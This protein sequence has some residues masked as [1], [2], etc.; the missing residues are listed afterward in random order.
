[1]GLA[2]QVRCQGIGKGGS[3][4]ADPPWVV[5]LG[6]SVDQR[7]DGMPS[8]VARTTACVRLWLGAWDE[9]QRQGSCNRSRMAMDTELAGKLRSRCLAR[10]PTL[11]LVKLLAYGYVHRVCGQT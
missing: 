6:Y 5:V 1:M 4:C 2:H 10:V 8:A 7:E 9:S 11:E 3:L